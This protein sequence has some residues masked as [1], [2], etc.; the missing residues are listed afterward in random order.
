MK[1]FYLIDGHAQIFRAYYAPFAQILTSPSGEP[2]KAT[3]IFT[4]M[5]LNII[6]NK[7]P[8]YLAVALDFGDDTTERK[9][10]FP[11]Y[12]ANRDRAPE[13][14]GPQVD[15]ITQ[16]LETLGVPQFVVKGQE[17]DDIIAT[18]ARLLADQ[19]IELRIASKDKDLHQ[20][21]TEKVKLWDPVKD[22]LIDPVSLEEKHGFTPEMAVELSNP[23][24]GFHRQHSGNSRGR[25]QEG[26]RLA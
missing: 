23:D 26:I 2:T 4:Q 11:E 24:G 18:I 20:I 3:Y 1:T 5:I 8:D 6:K 25:S 15:R 19:D 17:A 10:F 22:E 13:D 21:L 16:I 9:E 7:N 14:F 12:K